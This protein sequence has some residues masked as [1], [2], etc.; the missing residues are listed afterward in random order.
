MSERTT[1]PRTDT[2]VDGAGPAG[3]ACAIAACIFPGIDD[4]L[5]AGL[6]L[7]AS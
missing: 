6:Q 1:A 5:A 4:L 3:L 2:L 7:L